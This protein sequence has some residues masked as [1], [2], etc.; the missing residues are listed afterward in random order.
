MIEATLAGVSDMPETIISRVIAGDATKSPLSDTDREFLKNKFLN[1]LAGRWEITATTPPEQPPSVPWQ[2]TL[3]I[4]GNTVSGDVF[5]PLE[6]RFLRRQMRL[7]G[8][9]DWRFSFWGR[10]DDHEVI[11]DG[12]V[13]WLTASC[14]ASH[15]LMPR[16]AA[17]PR[18]ILSLRI[19]PAGEG[20]SRPQISAG[21]SCTTQAAAA[22][23]A[24]S[25]SEPERR[26]RATR[27]R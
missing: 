16:S 23:S 27:R 11:D 21:R 9:D 8:R 15:R 26:C 20:A 24:P 22:S 10:I 12:G 13:R 6:R 7:G 4:E 17:E 18:A 2:V 25:P 19:P 3:R 14:D 1:K 5:E